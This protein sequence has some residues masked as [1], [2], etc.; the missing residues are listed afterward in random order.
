[1]K[2]VPA[3]RILEVVDGEVLKVGSL[4]LKILYSPGHAPY[5]MSVLELKGGSLFTG[6]A[7]GMYVGEKGALWPASP[8]PSFRYE[9]AMETIGELRSQDPR[10]LLIPH[11][12]PQADVARIFDLN[13]KT[14]AAWHELLEAEPE[15]KGTK[16]VVDDILSSDP[17]YAWIRADRLT[18]W[19]VTMHAT[20]FRQA[21]SGLGKASE[22]QGQR[23]NSSG[24]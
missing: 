14:Y 22:P 20:G 21:L 17:S 5:H 6:D 3:E 16:E 4:H 18:R 15:G 1:M 19:I 23:G 11:Y 10:R 7:V 12:G 2:P 8:L 13:K 24:D 9:E